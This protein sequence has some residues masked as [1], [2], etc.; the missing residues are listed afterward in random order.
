MKIL[1]NEKKQAQCP[2]CGQ[3]VD[4]V[5]ND[6]VSQHEITHCNGRKWAIFISKEDLEKV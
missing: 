4:M 2:E 3:W 1:I 5:W 6:K